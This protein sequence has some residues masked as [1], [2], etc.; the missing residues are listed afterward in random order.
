MAITPQ[1]I[2][3][4]GTAVDISKRFATSSTLVASPATA[5]ET[6]IC[7]I[8]GLPADCSVFTGVFLSGI[9]SFT[10][11]TGGSA[12]R[13]RIRTGTTAGAG[14]VIAD[15][16]PITAG[17]SSANLVSQDVQGVDTG[18]VG[19]N[20]IGSTSYCLTLATT[21]GTASSNVSQTNLTAVIF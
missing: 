13:L 1:G 15:T 8:T 20:A 5:A 21:G 3:I 4:G 14:T 11:G 19:G 9:A 2:L 16:G 7:S 6:V 17:I 10:V 12:C 18:T